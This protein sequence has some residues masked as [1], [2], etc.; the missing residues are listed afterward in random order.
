MEQL[1]EGR[2]C[3][4]G[5][6]GKWVVDVSSARF[7]DHLDDPVVGIGQGEQ[8]RELLTADA[9]R[10]LFSEL[11]RQMYT[12]L[13]TYLVR[14][15]DVGLI[16]DVLAETFLVVWRRW[17]DLP[18]DSSGRRAWVYGV[19][20]NKI[21][22][23]TDML[24]R[25]LRLTW[26]AGRLLD[27]EAASDMLGLEALDEARRLLDLL[28]QGERD[29]LSL[30]VVAGLTSAETASALGCSVSSVTTRVARA[31]KRLLLILTEQDQG[32]EKA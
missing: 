24:N 8:Q 29:A 32:R 28:P 21:M 5:F 9:Q 10:E 22:Q 3:V 27:A 26:R 6:W 17:P 14:H 30:M 19:L 7:D 25:Q 15:L 13:R 2:V 31:R 18:E 12:E 4:L 16:D 1:L 11:Y 20:R 23:A